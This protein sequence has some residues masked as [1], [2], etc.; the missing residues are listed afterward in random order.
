[1]YDNIS[2]QSIDTSVVSNTVSVLR[3]VNKQINRNFDEMKKKS[4]LLNSWEGA[5]AGVTKTFYEKLLA[6]NEPRSEIFSNYP[7]LLELWVNPGYKYAE[8]KNKGLSDL[9]K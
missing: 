1:M 8:E 3:T 4:K 2:K 6:I 7:E 5:A 9:F